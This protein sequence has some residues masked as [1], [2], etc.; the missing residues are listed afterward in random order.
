MLFIALAVVVVE[1]IE[2]YPI[3]A[4]AVYTVVDKGVTIAARPTSGTVTSVVLDT[5]VARGSVLARHT[6]TI[7]DTL[8][9][10]YS[11]VACIAHTFKCTNLITT[12]R[13]SSG[14]TRVGVTF[15]NFCITVGSG[16]PNLAY[17]VVVADIGFTCSINAR[18]RVACGIILTVFAIE[19]RRTHARIISTL[20]IACGVILA[21]II[22]VAFY[23]GTACTAR[24]V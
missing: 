13:T 24:H 20:C 17:A 19:S 16:V 10:V 11:L 7:I 9:A 5:I 14:I 12:D 15:I 23:D 1:E 8:R 21:R 4:W 22:V 6:L 18:V 3:D 2:T